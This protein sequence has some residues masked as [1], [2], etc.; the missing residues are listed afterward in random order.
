MGPQPASTRTVQQSA[1]I[2]ELNDHMDIGERGNARV[3]KNGKPLLFS[4]KF[5]VY[6][7]GAASGSNC[8]EELL[9]MFEALDSALK[10]APPYK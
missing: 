7:D 4:R 10:R 3:D 2:S 8:L 1:Y 9:L 6:C 5:A